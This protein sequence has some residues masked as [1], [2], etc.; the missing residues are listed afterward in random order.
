MKR[1]V[2]P[3]PRI[4]EALADYVSVHIDIDAQPKIAS[5][6]NVSSVPVLI[7][8]NREG[9]V[10]ARADGDVSVDRLLHFLKGVPRPD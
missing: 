3:D 9:T 7:V 8:I 1:G 2:Y 10:L 5:Q 4:R 6:H